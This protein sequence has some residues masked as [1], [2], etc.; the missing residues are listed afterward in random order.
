MKVEEQGRS[1]NTAV[2][3]DQ[4]M[5]D[6][7]ISEAGNPGGAQLGDSDSRLDGGG[8]SSS[9]AVTGS[10]VGDPVLSTDMEELLEDD[11]NWDKGATIMVG[12]TQF[13]MGE[14]RQHIR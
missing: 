1:T 3:G 14:M 8:T 9:P 6:L 4:Q 10:W 12:R 7:I 2:D 13:Y 11:D 5:V